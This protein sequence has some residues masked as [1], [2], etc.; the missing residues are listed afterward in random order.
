MWSREEL[1]SRA[2][3]AF[4]RNYWKCVLVA[5]ILGIFAG[6]SAISTPGNLLSDLDNDEYY[7]D[8]DDYYEE[9]LGNVI[10]NALGGIILI[11][12][13]VV[14]VFG[15]VL[16]V[17][18]G[19]P[20]EVGGCNFFINNTYANANAGEM[21]SAFKSGCYWKSVSTVFMRNLYIALWSLL[22]V[23]PGIIKSYEYRMVTYLI[24]EYPNMSREEAFHI[25]KE[26]MRGQKMEAWL[27]DL[28]FIGW[29]LLVTITCGVAGIFYVAPYVQATNAELY[30][31]LR[32]QYFYSAQN[33]NQ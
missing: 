28:S 10:G 1:K 11:G 2:K 14:A 33:A 19:N 16:Q 30:I 5:F 8:Y 25:S 27:L 24:A 15:A 6:S 17:F 31:T 7:E 32:N 20:L 4:K 29:Y 23:V 26:M 12:I 3:V 21:L 9:D 22:L 18:V 13:A